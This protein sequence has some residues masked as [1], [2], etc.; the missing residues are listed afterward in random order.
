MRREWLERHLCYLLE[1][2]I[3]D[4]NAD[5]ASKIIMLKKIL[6][7]HTFDHNYELYRII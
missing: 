5:K 1:I 7:S 2:I 3:A 4:N 6:L